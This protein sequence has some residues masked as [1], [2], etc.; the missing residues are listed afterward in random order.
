MAR[1]A[2]GRARAR[3][4]PARAKVRW[5]DRT[6]GSPGGSEDGQG[7]DQARETEAAAGALMA[8]Q[9]LTDDFVRELQPPSANNK[10]YW[11]ADAPGVPYSGVSGFGIRITAAGFRA[12]VLHYRLRDGSGQNRTFTIGKHPYLNVERARLLARKL[13]E[14]IEIGADPQATK[15]A[16]RMVAKSHHLDVALTLHDRVA[17]KFASFIKDDIEPAG[18]LYRHYDPKGDLL[19]VGI[20][21]GISERTKSHLS[22][23]TW[24]EFICLII[25]EPFE[26]RE[27]LLEAERD[28]IINEF[29]K[30]N[31]VLNKRRH[32]VQEL[33]KREK[34]A[35]RRKERYVSQKSA[36]R[37]ANDQRFENVLARRAAEA[38]AAEEPA[39]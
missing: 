16:K 30:Y 17:A 6:A 11:D 37:Q 34:R 31:R 4:D 24:R 32:P 25:V 22:K 27:E 5:F 26:T 29:P 35:Q 23:A 33:E 39:E 8:S 18:Y 36:R 9:Y 21:Q 7:R 20:T 12:F 3:C 2:A 14:D 28:A 13:R 38:A 10:I 19:Y 1:V 15:N